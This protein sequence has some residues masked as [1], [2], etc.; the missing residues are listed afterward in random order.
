MSNETNINR[1][2]CNTFSQAQTLN[3]FKTFAK[4]MSNLLIDILDLSGVE[5][6]ENWKTNG[7]RASVTRE[8]QP[9]SNER[10]TNHNLSNERRF[11]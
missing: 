11:N 3:K 10:K 1:I 2:I 9:K 4:K 7:D 8:K 5:L 6:P